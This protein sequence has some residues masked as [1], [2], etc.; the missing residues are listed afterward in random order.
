MDTR[1]ARLACDAG[2]SETW[3]GEAP[4][5]PKVFTG[6]YVLN[7]VVVRAYI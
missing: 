3:W 7:G 5:R 4:E 6:G 1:G 2:R